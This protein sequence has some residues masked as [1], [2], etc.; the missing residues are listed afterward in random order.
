MSTLNETIKEY[1]L[2][3]KYDLEDGADLDMIYNGLKGLEED[4]DFLACAGVNMAIQEH[5][6]ET[7][8]SSDAG[9]DKLIQELIG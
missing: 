4:E 1:Y 8:E 5:L 7:K 9:F 2:M 3:V 6:A